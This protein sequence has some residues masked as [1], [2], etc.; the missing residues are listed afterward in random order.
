MKE[1]RE[2]ASKQTEKSADRYSE[3]TSDETLSDVESTQKI[4][5]KTSSSATTTENSSSVVAPDGMPGDARTGRAD[6]SDSGGPM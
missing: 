2:S 4:G 1:E 5:T 3:A 6:G